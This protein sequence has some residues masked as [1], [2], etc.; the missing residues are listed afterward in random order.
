MSKDW[1]K[2]KAE[3][4]MLEYEKKQMQNYVDEFR[5]KRTEESDNPWDEEKLE[6]IKLFIKELSE[7]QSPERKLRNKLLGIKYQIEDYLRDN[8]LDEEE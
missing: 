6:S 1:K 8:P 2:G 3:V 7:N 4:A 5:K